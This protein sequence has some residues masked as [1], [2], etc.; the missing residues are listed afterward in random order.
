VTI[1][2]DMQ[3]MMMAAQLMMSQQL[4]GTT[5]YRDLGYNWRQEQ[6]QLADEARFQ[7]EL[8]ARTQKEM[9]QAGTAGPMA[10]GQQQGQ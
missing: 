9:Q 1:A 5:A 4:S 7:S 2:D 10:K 8:Q 3:K 6:K